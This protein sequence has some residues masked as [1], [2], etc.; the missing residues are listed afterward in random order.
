MSLSLIVIT[1]L[2]IIKIFYILLSTQT[3]KMQA[4]NKSHFLSNP[5][6][7][8]GHIITDDKTKRYMNLNIVRGRAGVIHILVWMIFINTLFLDYS[9][10]PIVFY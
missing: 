7:A 9:L 5:W 8:P 2:K 3:N 6:Y 4:Q 1:V 10:K